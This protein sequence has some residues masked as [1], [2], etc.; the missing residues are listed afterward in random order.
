VNE[1]VLIGQCLNG[2]RDRDC[3]YCPAHS[4]RRGGCCFGLRHEYEDPDCTACVL[5]SE[6]EA[7]AH[8]GT[9]H[10]VRRTTPAPRIIYPGRSTAKAPVRTIVAPG[11]QT[12]HVQQG[13]V[14][15]MQDYGPQPGEPLLVQQPVQPEP[16]K[17]NPNDGLFRRFLKVSSWGAG[18]GFFEMGLNFFR[19]RR[20]E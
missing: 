9:K 12:R 16:L 1:E 11:T 10:D 14:V 7:L 6:C 4:S 5:E 8:A 15:V 13:R 3:E 19:K 18:E 2:E 20:P 17:L